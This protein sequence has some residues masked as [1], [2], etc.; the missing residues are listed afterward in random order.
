MR[1]WLPSLADL[2]FCCIFLRLTLA[3]DGW[4]LNDADTGYHIRA[5]EYILTYFTI[6]TH[7]IFSYITPSLPW[8]AH[9]WLSEVIMALIHR[10]SGLTGVVIFFSVWI[11]AAY[12]VL[13]KFSQALK[14]NL[15]V[16]ALLVLLATI[17]SSLHWLARPHIFS[18]LLT[19][20]WYAILANYQYLEKKHL[21][22]L[23]FLML[24][25]VNL[26]GGFIIGFVL[27]GVFLIGN[28][29]T[30]LSRAGFDRGPAKNKLTELALI[31]VLC[32]L[33]SLLNPRGY[34]ILLFPFSMVSNPFILQNVVEFLS[35]NFHEPL[36]Y[37]YLLLFSVGVLAVSRT[38][39]TAIDLILMLLFTYMSLYSSRY[40]PLFAI[41]VTPILLRHLQRML[42]QLDTAPARFLQRRSD[43]LRIMDAS[44]RAYIWPDVFVL[45]ACVLALSG[46]IKFKF[47]ERRLPVAAVDFLKKE[48]VKGNMFNN[49]EFGDYIIYAA[50][51]DYKVF[52]DGRSD[53]YGE[54]WGR[55]YLNVANIQPGWEKVIDDNDISW[56]IYNSGA[57]LSTLLLENKSW[58]LIYS[59]GVADIFVKRT[60]E[61]RHLIDKY[62]DIRRKEPTGAQTARK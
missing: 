2:F 19:V 42:Q 55:Q 43:N 30:S 50:W 13:F 16:T 38:G 22:W 9:E 45:G 59:D 57:P 5:G 40:I 32:L 47:D 31:T 8:T 56:V 61:H 18:L 14:C 21:F 62:T 36:P 17:S 15:I 49:E 52:F 37:K 29:I 53:M 23:P 6:P 34:T 46:A 24:F 12:Y 11:G 7:D 35:P 27:L 26:H 1:P 20:L 33:A 25:W 3:G 4:L 10:F 60:A 28:L 48:P 44:T 39:L 54:S 58:Q 51:P 41:I